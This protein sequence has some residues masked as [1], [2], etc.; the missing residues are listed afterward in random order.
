MLCTG[1]MFNYTLKTF[2]LMVSITL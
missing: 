1:I 2:H